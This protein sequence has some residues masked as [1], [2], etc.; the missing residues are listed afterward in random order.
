M[1]QLINGSRLNDGSVPFDDV[2]GTERSPGGAS[3]VPPTSSAPPPEGVG[4][5][6][7]VQETP[8]AP[9]M[10][11]ATPV[12]PEIPDDWE[13]V[14]GSEADRNVDRMV[15]PYVDEQ[16][17]LQIPKTLMGRS[18]ARRLAKAEVP[19]KSPMAMTPEQRLLILDTWRRSG[20]PAGDFAEMVGMSKHTL[21]SWKNKFEKLG[22][23]GL[24][25]QP[26]GKHGSRLSDVARRSIL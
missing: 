5:S 7:P 25:D 12:A 3:G 26:K 16:V 17:D 22:P 20:L 6:P 8:V 10:P 24:M 18:K 4:T 11:P 9:A 23:A 14:E 13:P 15:E 21:Y 19:A 1:S 2:G